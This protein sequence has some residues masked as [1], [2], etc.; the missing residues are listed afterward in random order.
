MISTAMAFSDDFAAPWNVYMVFGFD[1]I[2]SHQNYVQHLYPSFF[3][4]DHTIFRR[5]QL[6][7]G[8]VSGFFSKLFLV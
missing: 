8:P 5:L 7:L 1:T 6:D 4:Y 3:K 2:S